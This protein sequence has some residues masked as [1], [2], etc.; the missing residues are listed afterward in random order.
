M[1]KNFIN[2][3]SLGKI[4]CI[5]VLRIFETYAKLEE[6]LSNYEH[7]VPIML[8][9]ELIGYAKQD[10]LKF[11]MPAKEIFADIILKYPL[12]IQDWNYLQKRFNVYLRITN[13]QRNVYLVCS[14]PNGGEKIDFNGKN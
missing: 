10:S 12:K 3:T 1:T 2:L 6:C 5:D 14:I 13:N 8:D 4:D 11:L 7:P 9:G